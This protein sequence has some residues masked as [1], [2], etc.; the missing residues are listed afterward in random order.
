MKKQYLKEVIDKIVKQTLMEMACNNLSFRNFIVDMKKMGFEYEEAAG[1][2]KVFKIPEYGDKSLITVHAHD[3]NAPLDGNT[4]RTVRD[5]LKK[6]GWFNKPENFRKFP[7]EKWQISTNDIKIDTSKQQTEDANEFFKNAEVV[8]VF[9]MKNSI[10][11]LKHNNKVNLCRNVNDKRPLLTKWFD[12]Y[13][14]DRK[15][16]TIPC[17]KINDWENFE[18]KCYPIKKDGTLD[19]N[20]LIIENKR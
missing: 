19:T 13:A 9:P 3:K 4:L 10:C 1:S 11:V 14:F 15:T 18:T 5:V 2:A 16:G 8:P 17:L 6:I 7:F 12:N 20:N